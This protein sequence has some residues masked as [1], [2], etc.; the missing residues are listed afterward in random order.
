VRYEELVYPHYETPLVEAYGQRYESVYIVLHPFVRMPDALAWRVL[1]KYP[2]D[3]QILACGSKVP[4]MQVAEETGLPNCA[5]VNQ[6]LL[7]STGAV[8]EHLCDSDACERLVRYAQSG[9][10]WMPGSGEFEALLHADFIAAFESAGMAELVYVPEFPQIDPIRHVSLAGL[11]DGSVPFPPRG[12]LVAPDASFLFTVDW[13]SFF[14]LF[15]G[16]REFVT[17]V[18]R[19]RSLEG[20]F[21]A[22]TTEHFWFNYSMGCATVTLS[23]EH[24]S[25]V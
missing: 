8:K 18:A 6:A 9:Q 2:A 12:S 11:K 24:W 20:F 25:A 14:T 1:Q 5:R 21:A 13:D 19:A 22:A 17:R 4:W 15:Y 23:P 7:T 10:V 3:E 16:S